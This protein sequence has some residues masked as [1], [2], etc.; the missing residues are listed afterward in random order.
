MVCKKPLR[1]QGIQWRLHQLLDSY[2]NTPIIGKLWVHISNNVDREAFYIMLLEG[3]YILPTGK[4]FSGG[5]TRTTSMHDDTT[6][7]FMHNP[8]YKYPQQKPFYMQ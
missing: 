3:F 8:P 2:V 1:V 6:R 5:V 7:A 4:V